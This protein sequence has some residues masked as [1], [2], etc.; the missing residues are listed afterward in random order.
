MA[1]VL[2]LGPEHSVLARE[3]EERAGLMAAA[4]AYVAT[5]PGNEVLGGG[6]LDWLRGPP[7]AVV[8]V[9]GC[10]DGLHPGHQQLLRLAAGAGGAFQTTK[11]LVGVND[12]SYIRQVKQAEPLADQGIRANTVSRFLVGLKV[13]HEVHKIGW[14]P[15]DLIRQTRPHA[16]VK[17][18][19]DVLSEAE[20][21]A[22]RD[23]K[24]SV[25][26]VDRLPGH[27]STDLRKAK[28]QQA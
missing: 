28:A 21:A 9:N 3:D 27:S 23:C 10:F 11:V 25:L 2:A 4:G 5:K 20:Q 1:A 13:R 16:L 14:D 19:P 24:V 17:T 7:E 26:L 22:V 8:L 12:D 15:S 6:L 18:V